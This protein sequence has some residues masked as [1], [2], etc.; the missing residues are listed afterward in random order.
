MILE[1][2]LTSTKLE[3][4]FEIANNFFYSKRAPDADP[5]GCPNASVR[6]F[7]S[8]GKTAFSIFKIYA[9]RSA[10]GAKSK[11]TVIDM[12]ATQATFLR[13]SYTQFAE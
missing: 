2:T 5:R 10:A 12:S 9:K 4:E 11:R 3:A 13:K 7:L 1:T 8:L 6:Y